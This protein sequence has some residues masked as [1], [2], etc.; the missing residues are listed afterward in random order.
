MRTKDHVRLGPWVAEVFHFNSKTRR[1]AILI[2]KSSS[3]TLFKM[4]SA[5]EGW[6]LIIL[7][8][9]FHVPVLMLNVHVP[10]FDSPNFMNKLF[11]NLPSLNHW[12]IFGG[13]MNC[14]IDPQID[15]SEPGSTQPLMAKTLS[16]F[17]SSNGCVDPWRFRNPTGRQYSFY[18]H[19]H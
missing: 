18:S 15:C 5:K 19:V 2:D 11:E 7:G 9:L 13:D 14:A 10:H 6:Y 17:M 4:I 8:T 3:F 12:L 1:V 16:D